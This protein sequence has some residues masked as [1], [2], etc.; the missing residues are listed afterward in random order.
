MLVVP[1]SNG[2]LYGIRADDGR[3]EWTNQPY[4]VILAEPIVVDD[5]VYVIESEKGILRQH[6]INEG[7]Q[8]WRSDCEKDDSCGD[9]VLA[10]FSIAPSGNVIYYGD[11]SGHITA[12]QVANFE[13]PVP[14]DSPSL[15]P[16]ATPRPT[17]TAS[18]TQF[19]PPSS[20]P[21]DSSDDSLVADGENLKQHEGEDSDETAVVVAS[22]VSGLIL[23][24]ALVAVWFFVGR[25]RKNKNDT[26]PKKDS[27]NASDR[28]LEHG[29]S[30]MPR[31]ISLFRKKHSPPPT[32]NVDI[33]EEVRSIRMHE[34]DDSTRDLNDTFSLAAESECDDAGD[35]ADN[36]IILKE[37]LPCDRSCES[38]S[39]DSNDN[40]DTE[41]PVPSQVPEDL[42]TPSADTH[43]IETKGEDKEEPTEST[44]FNHMYAADSSVAK[45]DASHPDPPASP[46]LTYSEASYADPPESPISTCSES[47]LYMGS[48]TVKSIDGS[49]YNTPNFI[50]TVSN[51]YGTSVNTGYNEDAP[52]TEAAS[53]SSQHSQ[54]SDRTNNEDEVDRG[55]SSAPDDEENARGAPGAH[56]MVNSSMENPK[57]LDNVGR[58]SSLRSVR[59][60]DKAPGLAEEGVQQGGIENWDSFMD[61]LAEAEKMF[62]Q[63]NLKS[64]NLLSDDEST[65]AGSSIMS[66]F[67]Q[68]R[69][70]LLGSD[71]SL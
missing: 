10:D 28:D 14:T 59:Q 19:I 16:T 12:T 30:R 35:N 49:N 15:S 1:G 27:G 52:A 55:Y 58:S 31:N 60:M 8:F 50:P 42:D 11:V 53:A 66:Y 25:R 40:F 29:F 37:M 61:E 70:A 47:S 6:S 7:V 46:T 23:A 62:S 9:K 67:D 17:M 48:V 36:P 21:T 39:D 20:Q 3:V 64:S 54:C 13:T 22:V 32:M 43:A 24:G 57:S 65:D 26:G 44:S 33:D 45:S 18:P 4:S 56:Y 68:A 38:G 41:G 51:T 2:E 63:P 5:I 71:S 69:S 34:A